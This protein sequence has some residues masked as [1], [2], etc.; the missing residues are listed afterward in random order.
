MADVLLAVQMEKLRVE[1]ALAARDNVV[2]CLEDAYTSVRQKAATILRLE[3]ELETLK[4]PSTPANANLEVTFLKLPGTPQP[5][6]QS[7]PRQ[8]F[9]ELDEQQASSVVYSGIQM[10]LKKAKLRRGLRRELRILQEGC[11]MTLRARPTRI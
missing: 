7:S 5:Q 8:A 11:Q 2:A 10:K 6:P 1:E 3:R 4:R 9:E